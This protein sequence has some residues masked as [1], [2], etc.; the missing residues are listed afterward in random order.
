MTVLVSLRECVRCAFTP[1]ATQVAQWD[2]YPLISITGFIVILALSVVV[3]SIVSNNTSNILRRPCV[4]TLW[5][6]P[7]VCL[8]V[9][10][11]PTSQTYF[12]CDVVR[13]DGD[14]SGDDEPLTINT[15]RCVNN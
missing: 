4:E 12:I 15:N 1:L 14:D 6:S 13:Q 2:T 7:N 3:Q 8:I 5:Y 11:I 9:L 10:L